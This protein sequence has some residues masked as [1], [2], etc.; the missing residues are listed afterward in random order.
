MVN[1]QDLQQQIIFLGTRTNIFL[2]IS[3][4]CSISAEYKNKQIIHKNHL[5]QDIIHKNIC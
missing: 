5:T 3:Q 1:C 2:S 4:D